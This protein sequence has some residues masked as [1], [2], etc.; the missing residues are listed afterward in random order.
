MPQSPPQHGDDERIDDY[1]CGRLTPEQQLEFEAE[2]IGNPDL[3]KKIEAA[4]VL[5]QCLT[6]ATMQRAFNGSGTSSW[7]KKCWQ[8]FA[9]PQTLAGAVAA[10]FLL[11]PFCVQLYKN[12]GQEFDS[13][14]Y[15]APIERDRSG[16]GQ[17]NAGFQ[18]YV[19]EGEQVLMVFDLPVPATTGKVAYW[20]VELID[21]EKQVVWRK[22]G[23]PNNAFSI[24]QIMVESNVFK[25][26]IY[27]YR[28][29]SKESSLLSSGTIKIGDE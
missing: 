2:F 25:N 11:I 1:V 28:V 26:G 8:Y 6:E 12:S 22:A 29:L 15:I 27:T 4:Y 17:L 20:D 9:V 3:V 10:A 16:S 14:S 13:I 21:N 24:V 23:Q 7:L 5:K 19:T 18:A